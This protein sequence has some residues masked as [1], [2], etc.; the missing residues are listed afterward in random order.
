MRGLYQIETVCA[1]AE[2]H[3]QDRDVA[4]VLE[5]LDIPLKLVLGGGGVLVQR[6]VGD[7]ILIQGGSDDVQHVRPGGEHETLG[8][9][10]LRPNPH[11]AF[12]HCFHLCTT[13][14]D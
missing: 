3:Q 1:L 2:R 6:G 8:S 9:L 13:N 14:Y 11:Q 5:P 7:V 10:V 12:Q 4:A